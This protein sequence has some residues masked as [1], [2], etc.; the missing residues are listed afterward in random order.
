MHLL[1]RGTG[2]G[3]TG[4]SASLLPMGKE[5]LSLWCITG[6]QNRLERTWYTSWDTIN[7]AYD[8]YMYYDVAID[9]TVPPWR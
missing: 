5:A 2:K 6:Q 1:T 8:Y 3:P 9:R 4:T 7:P